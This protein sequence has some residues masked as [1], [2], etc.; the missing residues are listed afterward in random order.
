MHKSP[1]AAK[2]KQNSL[3]VSHVPPKVIDWINTR[4]QQ[5][6]QQQQQQHKQQQKQA[7]YS[8]QCISI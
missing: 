2:K 4:Q 1:I 5:Q 3:I 7:K 8:N 6:Q